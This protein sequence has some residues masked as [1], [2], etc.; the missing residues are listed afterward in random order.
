MDPE[1]ERYE[2]HFLIDG[3]TQ[4]HQ[5][6]IS[7][8]R[9][10]VIG[11]GGLGSP[12]LQ[13]LCGAGT[14]TLGLVEFDS[15]ALSNLHRQILYA[16]SDVGLPK[17]RLAADRLSAINPV[18]N[19][20][21]FEEQWKTENAERIAADFDILIDCSDNLLSRRV[22]DQASKKIGIPFVYGAVHQMEGQVAVFNYNG[23]KSYADLF[24]EKSVPPVRKPIG[25]LGPAPGV[26]GSYQAAE[27]LKIIT[28]IGEV[29]AD[30]IMYISLRTN[31]NQIMNY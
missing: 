30:K 18:C 14:G 26:I 31:R 4:E 28:G 27:A 15:L 22:S 20:L 1:K 13:Y 23:S 8:A 19:I 11:A 7:S 21:L 2:R 5:A 3:F 10:L 29:L 12:V 9:V 6:K 25:V 24:P 16:S 17:A